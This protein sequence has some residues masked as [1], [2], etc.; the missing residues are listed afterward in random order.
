MADDRLPSN[1]RV[2]DVMSADDLEVV[3]ADDTVHQVIYLMGK[4]QVRRIPVVARDNRLLGIIAMADIARR[5]DLDEEL[6]V[7]EP[8]DQVT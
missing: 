4:N 1:V 7:L 3:T 6:V 5:A 2:A 8:R